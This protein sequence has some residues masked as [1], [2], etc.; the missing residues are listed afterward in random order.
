MGFARRWIIGLGFVCLAL[1][2]PAP[3]AA[4]TITVFAA[5]SL[6]EAVGELAR[7]FEHVS[8]L[9]VKTSFAASSA[10]AR[11][12]VSGAPAD[13]FISADTAWMDDLQSRGLIRTASRCNLAG[14]SL[15][16]IAPAAS[17]VR[18][19]IG[20]HFPI[21]AALG[22]GRL[23]IGDPDSVPVGRYSRAALTALGVWP[24]VSANLVRADNVRVALEFVARGEV[25]LGVVYRTDAIIDP[26][27]RIV[28]EFPAGTHAPIVYPAALTVS[29]HAGTG[30]LLAFMR[31]PAGAAIFKKYGFEQIH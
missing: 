11:Q 13:L 7:A 31:G 22:G 24:E 27:V 9:R 26:A 17:R 10:L 30:R 4:S 21:G 25:P 16:L 20:P 23:A 1:Q 15:V 14:N 2:V 3:A 12:I 29:A 6:T 19:T 28:G 18:L 8:G 5:S